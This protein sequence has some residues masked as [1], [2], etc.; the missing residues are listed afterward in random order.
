MTVSL[1]CSPSIG[2]ISK[3]TFE[4]RSAARRAR[5]DSSTSTVC[6]HSG[7]KA[8]QVYDRRV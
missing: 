6:A 4:R 7:V 8:C 1:T 5:R 3:V 2:S